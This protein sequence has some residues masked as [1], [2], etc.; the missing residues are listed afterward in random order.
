MRIGFLITARLKSTR[1]PLKIMKDLN[2]GLV[3]QR[4]VERAREIHNIAPSDII[5]CTS[6]NPQDKPLIDIAHATGV[7]VFLGDPEDVL[8]RLHDAAL[9]HKLDYALGITADNPLFSIEYSNKIVERIHQ[10]RPDFIKIQG[11]PFGAATWGMNIKALRTICKVKPIV[12]TEIWG[13][14]IDRPELFT[15]ETIEADATVRRPQYRLT[16]DYKEDY[17]LLNH[18]YTHIPFRTT[19]SLRSVVTYLDAHPE[20][21]AINKGCIQLDLDKAMKEHI[22]KMYKEHFKKIQKIKQDIYT[23]KAP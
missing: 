3:I 1:L 9:L 23:E 10:E 16:L 4:I 2:G 21:V 19:L 5:I 6:P 22:D 13:Y 11:L 15:V 20:V 12:D 17:E 7:S 14:L 8:K 18:L